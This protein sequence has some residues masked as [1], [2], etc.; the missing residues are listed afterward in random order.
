MFESQDA[1]TKERVA[2]VD[3]IIK[4]LRI[5]ND[6]GGVCRLGQGALI[7]TGKA[8]KVGIFTFQRLDPI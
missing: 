7:V 4:L 5:V 8:D 1:V 6:D 2:P 3:I